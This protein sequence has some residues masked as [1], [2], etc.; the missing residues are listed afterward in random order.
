MVAFKPQTPWSLSTGGPSEFHEH[1]KDTPLLSYL[2]WVEFPAQQ[3]RQPNP[4]TNARIHR[5]D[6]RGAAEPRG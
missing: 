3:Q 4:G 1:S 5:I 6:T 2:V